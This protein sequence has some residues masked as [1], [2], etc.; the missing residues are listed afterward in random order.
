MLHFQLDGPFGGVGNSGSGAYHGKAGF[1]EFT[2]RRVVASQEGKYGSSTGMVGASLASPE[3]EEGINT[4]VAGAL[5]MVRER[6][7]K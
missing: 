3:F 6:M 7:G 5:A 1:D 2:H 4:A